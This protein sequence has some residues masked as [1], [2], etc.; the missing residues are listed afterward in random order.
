MYLFSVSDNEDEDENEA[1]NGNDDVQ[2]EI[3]SRNI[4]IDFDLNIA[5]RI[6]PLTP[7]NGAVLTRVESLKI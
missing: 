6:E 7:I 5:I 1:S 3:S 4:A 2:G